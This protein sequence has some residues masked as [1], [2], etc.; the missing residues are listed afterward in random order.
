M[1]KKKKKRCGDT[2]SLKSTSDQTGTT[3]PHPNRLPGPHKAESQTTQSL[4]Q[5]QEERTE[6]LA[7]TLTILGEGVQGRGPTSALR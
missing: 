5:Q 2:L 3:S 1:R 4:Y 6:K 7:G